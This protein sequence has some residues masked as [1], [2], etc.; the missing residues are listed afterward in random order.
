MEIA[1]RIR[2]E[3]PFGWFVTLCL[4]QAAD[5]AAADDRVRYGIVDWSA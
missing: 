2:L 1:D 4:R 3:L 5:V